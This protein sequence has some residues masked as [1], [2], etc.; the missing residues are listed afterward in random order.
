M[1]ENKHKIN[2]HYNKLISEIYPLHFL[3]EILTLILMTYWFSAK[4]CG[5]IHNKLMYSVL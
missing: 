3:D 2:K 1:N 4:D 5:D